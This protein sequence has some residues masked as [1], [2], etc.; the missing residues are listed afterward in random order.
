MKEI[1]VSVLMS[2]YFKDNPRF[3]E[4]S[5]DSIFNQTFMPNEIVII[6]D[7][8]ITNSL[9]NV[10]SI[11]NRKKGIIKIVELEKNSG[12]GIALNHGLEHC[13]NEIVARMDADDIARSD[14]LE[15]QYCYMCD[16]PDVSVLGAYVEEFENE[17]GDLKKI[18]K[19]PQDANK[20]KVFS[21][22]RNPLNHPSVMFRRNAVI[23]VG[24][25]SDLLFFED[26]YLWINLL[27]NNFIIVNLPEVLLYFRADSEMMRRRQGF[28]YLKFELAFLKRIYQ[29][30][31]I[32]IY[33]YVF[34]ATSKSFL[35]ILPIPLL[36]F[37]YRTYLRK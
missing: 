8:A 34:L 18:R 28:H 13:T 30:R 35:R 17:I 1:P 25:Y 29:D 6:K 10:L 12:L 37:F 20:V 2:V 24:G 9:N 19:T 23:K 4:Q 11:Y 27:I 16:H 21:K 5:L 3:F 33:E 7:G 26:Y 14:R 15:K 22:Y 36:K 32:N 31:Y